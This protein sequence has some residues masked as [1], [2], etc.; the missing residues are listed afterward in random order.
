MKSFKL[1]LLALSVA[2]LMSCTKLYYQVAQTK[3]LDQSVIKTADDN[4]YF[5]EDQFCRIEYDFWAEKGD[6]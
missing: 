3:P 2:G 5:Y 1:A 4:S 6:V